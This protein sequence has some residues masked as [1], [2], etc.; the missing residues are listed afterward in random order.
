MYQYQFIVEGLTLMYCWY[1]RCGRRS[2]RSWTTRTASMELW[3]SL[4]SETYRAAV[5]SIWMRLSPS[6]PL[7]CLAFSCNDVFQNG[8]MSYSNG[9]TS[10][11][12]LI[13]KRNSKNKNKINSELMSLCNLKCDYGDLTED[14]NNRDSQGVSPGYSQWSPHTLST[15]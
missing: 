1:S 11:A 7:A 10:S 8:E 13:Q 5:N 15:D 4:Q 2:M 9:A 3:P 6:V 12:A 14:R